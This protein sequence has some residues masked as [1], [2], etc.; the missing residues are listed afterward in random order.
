MNKVKHNFR[1]FKHMINL[2][3]IFVLLYFNNLIIT[4]NKTKQTH[5]HLIGACRNPIDSIVAAH[6]CVRAAID[7]FPE[8]GEKCR[9]QIVLRH[10]TV[11]TEPEINSQ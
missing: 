6:Y 10:F 2:N 8:C 11:E 9:A 7:T 5:H 4:T 3:F 1:Y